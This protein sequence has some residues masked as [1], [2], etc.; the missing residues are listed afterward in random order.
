MTEPHFH[1]IVIETCQRNGGA[2]EDPYHT[3]V[4]PC[5]F[6]HP[7]ETT[8]LKTLEKALT[9]IQPVA[10]NFDDG[11]FACITFFDATDFDSSDA[12]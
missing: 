12:E 6:C 5:N 11:M 2:Q 10:A 7:A 4:G 1:N 8:A 9:N 3:D